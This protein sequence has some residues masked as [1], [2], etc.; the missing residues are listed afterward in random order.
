M[1]NDEV[2]VSEFERRSAEFLKKYQENVAKLEPKRVPSKRPAEAQDKKADSEAQA[3]ASGDYDEVERK[4]H[5]AETQTIVETNLDRR[6]NRKLR[7]KYAKWVFCYLVCYSVAV[8]IL[9]IAAG[10]K[11]CGFDLSTSVLEFLVGSTAVSAI[12]LVL[13][14]TT[15]LFRGNNH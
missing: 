8:L 5:K 6:V 9:L 3:I 14:V 4:R 7:W 1:S 2:D 15:G 12:G 11:I 13:A 10:F